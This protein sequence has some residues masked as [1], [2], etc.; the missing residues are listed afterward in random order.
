MGNF[1]ILVLKVLEAYYRLP[2][3]NTWQL[4]FDHQFITAYKRD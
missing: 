3:Y 2:V 1:L 4:T